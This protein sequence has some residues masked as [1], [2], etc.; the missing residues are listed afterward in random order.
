VNLAQQHPTGI[1]GTLAA[2]AV[3]IAS[4]FGADISAT[5][6]AVVIGALVA[7]ASLF[8]PRFEKS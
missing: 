8:T 7:V 4:W 5:D 2:A 3:V 1:V 6:A